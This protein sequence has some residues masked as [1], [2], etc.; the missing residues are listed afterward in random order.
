MTMRSR[1]LALLAVPFAWTATLSA[2]AIPS[3]SAIHA[4][5]A[6]RIDSGRAVGI[7]VGI[8][9][10]G[11]RRFVWRGSAGPGRAPLGAHT[12]FEIGSITKTFNALVLADEV[13]RGALQLDLPVANLLPGVSM[14][15]HANGAITLEHLAT[16][17][18]GLPRLPGN[19]QPSNPGDPYADYDTTRLHAFLRSYTLPRAPGATAEYSNLGAGLLGHALTRHAGAASWSDL[20]RR[21]VLDPLGM[22]ETFAMVPMDDRPRLAAGHGISMDTV[23]YWHFD[24]LAGAGALRSTAADMLTYL[25][26]QLAPQRTTL[27]D[28]ITLAQEPRADFLGGSRIALGWLVRGD[29]TARMWSHGGGT[30]GFSTLAAFVPARGLG[31]VVLSNAGVPVDDIAMH[32]VDPAVPLRMPPVPPRRTAIALAADALEPLVGEYPLAPTFVMSITREGDA[33]YL[34]A[35]GQPRVR[36]WPSARDR[37]FLREVDAQL[38]F[39]L[40]ATGRATAVTL[41]QNGRE[42]TAQRRP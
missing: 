37:F 10:N 19:L 3:D 12:L 31:I 28:A 11:R 36:L 42:Q 29:S 25:E 24:V 4:I 15:A 13:S 39:T 41:V 30:A 1:L 5:V 6:A 17:R 34:Q 14:P 20:V 21:R 23:P 22:N 26:A 33:L 7:V 9:E 18:S 16:H 8:T 40:D 32:L 27:A 2:Q 35:T 38:V